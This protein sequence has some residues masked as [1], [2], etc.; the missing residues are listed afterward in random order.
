MDEP[1]GTGGD[2]SSTDRT[3]IEVLD[4]D[5][6]HRL[7]DAHRIGRVA[8]VVAGEPRIFP[9]NYARDGRSVVFITAPG[10]KLD[11]AVIN[12]PMA[13]QI[14]EWDT[15]AHTGWSVLVVGTA[16]EIGDPAEIE[17]LAASAPPVPWAPHPTRSRWVRIRP[18]EITG[19]RLGGRS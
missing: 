12:K 10:E 8:F 2:G 7:L 1:A 6:C 3:G 13:F 9:V 4:I 14:D 19:R 15:G 16:E 5:E 17:R 11:A 18:T